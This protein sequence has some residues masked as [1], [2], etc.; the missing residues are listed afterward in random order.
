MAVKVYFSD[1][2]SADAIGCLFERALS[3]TGGKI[4]K[5]DRVAVKVHFGEEGNTRFVSP[6]NLRPVL[7]R[8]AVRNGNHFLTDANA[9]YRG[10]RHNATDHL[11]I[12]REHGF[13]E[14]GV[15]LLIADGERGEEEE[16][17]TVL[18]TQAKRT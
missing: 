16:E 12:D 4:A 6:A 11:E 3:E 1:T 15:P 2:F 7:S 5:G 13:C 10:R 9:L 14:L 17:V 18:L 8:L